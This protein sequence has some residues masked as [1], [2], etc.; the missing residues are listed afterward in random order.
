MSAT[1]ERPETTGS[2]GSG[3]TTIQSK[4]TEE[5]SEFSFLN[6]VLLMVIAPLCLVFVIL[7]IHQVI[8][9]KR[10]Y[11]EM[12]VSNSGPSLP[13]CHPDDELKKAL[14]YLINHIEKKN[15]KIDNF[16]I[17]TTL[18]KFGCVPLN[19][20]EI[21]SSELMKMLIEMKKQQNKDLKA[22]K[23]EALEIKKL[24]QEVDLQE[25]KFSLQKQEFSL[26]AIKKYSVII[27]V[28]VGVVE[29]TLLTIK[30]LSKKPDEKKKEKDSDHPL[31]KKEDKL[32]QGY[33]V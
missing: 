3:N 15:Y 27:S 24:E 10:T 26:N 19:G 33:E 12:R 16:T 22:A 28:G 11:I 4:K 31:I 8:T 25:Q 20:R 5:E 9:I 30:Y 23:K 32:T 1:A 14:E 13:D 6:N 2:G 21:K 17:Q 29:T 18:E 7:S